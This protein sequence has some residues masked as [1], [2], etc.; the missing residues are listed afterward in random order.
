[1]TYHRGAMNRS[2][3][4]AL[5]VFA[6]LSLLAFRSHA[7]AAPAAPASSDVEIRELVRLVNRHRVEKGLR[8]LAWDARLAAVARRHSR[9]M[10]RRRFFG[11]VN[12]DGQDPFDRMRAAGLRFRAAGENVAEGQ[13]SAAEV[14]SAWIKSRHHRANIEGRDFSRQGIGLYRKRWTHL[15]LGEESRRR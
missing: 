14:F 3:S 2:V 10:A 8:P 7:V 9:D 15:F 12:P 1:M 6:A 13:S 5:T 11:H 4:R